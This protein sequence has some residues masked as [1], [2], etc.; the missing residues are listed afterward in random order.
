LFDDII[1]FHCH[2]GLSG[3]YFLFI[4]LTLDSRQLL[5]SA[6]LSIF[7]TN[8]RKCRYRERK[9][10]KEISSALSVENWNVTG[11]YC[12]INAQMD[13]GKNYSLEIKI[14]FH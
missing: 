5:F 11:C 2:I 1:K 3:F 8:P 7:T 10:H 9:N 6:S 14:F 4:F 13:G 12:P